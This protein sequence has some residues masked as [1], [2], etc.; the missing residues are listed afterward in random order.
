M[1][2][3]KRSFLKE[4]SALTVGASFVPLQS[5]QAFMPARREGDENKRYAML[6]DLRKCIGCQ[7][8]TVSC[9]VE[10][11]TP[12]HSFRTTVRQYEITNG[13]QVVNNVVLPRLCNHCDQPPCVPVC[14]VQATFQRKDGIVVINNEQCIGCGYCVQACPYDARFINEETKTADKCTFCTHRLEAGLLPACVES[15]VGG[16]RV[17][18]DLNDPKS[19]ISQLYQAHKDDLKVLK[20]EAGTVPHVFYVGLDDA[21]VSKIDGQPMLWTG[22]A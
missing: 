2:L 11:A 5:A 3:S 16:A 20:P 6:I 1:D 18:G 21:F 9:S 22:E 17:I 13:T 7:A 12:L 15:C 14:P 4:L 10:N 19:Q 8:C